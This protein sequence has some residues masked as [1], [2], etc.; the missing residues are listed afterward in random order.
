MSNSHV[1]FQEAVMAAIICSHHE[2]NKQKTAHNKV[3]IKAERLQQEI[4]VTAVFLQHV[5]MYVE[6][7]QC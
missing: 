5:M 2:S 4:K 6:G 7:L 1:S 3:D